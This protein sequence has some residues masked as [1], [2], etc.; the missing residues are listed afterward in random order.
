[1]QFKWRMGKC[2][3]DIAHKL[4][5]DSLNP[6]IIMLKKKISRYNPSIIFR[7]NLI[8]AQYRDNRD[9]FEDEE[10]DTAEAP[11]EPV[12]DAKEQ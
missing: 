1:M 2:Y 6:S 4:S 3:N 9:E 11:Q 8:M 12:A 10:T 7:N 5:R